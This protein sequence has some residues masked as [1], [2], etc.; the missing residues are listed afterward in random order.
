MTSDRTDEAFWDLAGPLLAQAGVTRSTMMGHP[1]LRLDGDFFASWDRQA[2]RLVIKLDAASV[3]DMIERDEA[4]A[5]APAG[6][7][8]REWAAVP[9]TR[10][11][12][13]PALLERALLAAVGRRG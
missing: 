4:E 11:A 10:R 6:R 12:N 5:F 8:F 13:W 1:C 2:Q 3:Q 7:A 9:T